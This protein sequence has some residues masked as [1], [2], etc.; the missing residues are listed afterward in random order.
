MI[1]EIMPDNTQQESLQEA[2]ALLAVNN[3]NLTWDEF[4]ALCGIAPRAFKTYRMPAA[5]KD[6]RTMSKLARNAVE[7]AVKANL[8][9]KRK[10]A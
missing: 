3:P 10:K 8:K 1:F 6:F 2:K 4:A 7:M 5:S 9:K